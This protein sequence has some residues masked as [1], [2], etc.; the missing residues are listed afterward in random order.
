MKNEKY[1]NKNNIEV[2]LRYKVKNKKKLLKW[3][4]KNA[5]KAYEFR[6]ID[7]Y[8]TP[9]HKNYF[10]KKYPSEYLRIRKSGD[11]YSITY[12]YWHS[13]GGGKEY[14]HCDEYKTDVEDGKQMRKIFKALNFKLLVVVD[15]HRTAYNYKNFEIVI[16]VVKSLGTICEV[17]VKG[18]YKS[19]DEAQKMIRELAGE[20]D[21]TKADRGDD[22]KLGYAYLI[23]KKKGIVKL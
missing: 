2:E 22:L 7:E 8:Y 17:E 3:L 15:K 13:K 5:K 4:E 20:L 6:Q 10:D 23:A 9:A 14:S 21:F 12:K 18:M 1:M 16:D 11:K 19:V